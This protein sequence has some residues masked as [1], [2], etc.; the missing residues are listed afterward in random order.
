M[1]EYLHHRSALRHSFLDV[2]RIEMGMYDILTDFEQARISASIMQEQCRRQVLLQSRRDRAAIRVIFQPHEQMPPIPLEYIKHFCDRIWLKG[3]QACFNFR[4][5][6][7]EAIGNVAASQYLLM[8]DLLHSTARE[9]IR[10]YKKGDRLIN[11]SV[12]FLRA[13]LAWH[14]LF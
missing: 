13:S 12:R 4:G 10:Q 5:I 2:Q 11:Q 6:C 7:L 9:D 1:D 14:L 3:R 8:Q